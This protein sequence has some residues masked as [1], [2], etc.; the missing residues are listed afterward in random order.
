MPAADP[1]KTLQMARDALSLERERAKDQPACLIVIRG[2]PQGRRYTL[3]KPSTVIGRDA[4]ADIVINDGNVSRRHAEVCLEGD[5]VTLKDCGSTN[6][7]L[8]NTTKV[9][10]AVTLR[11]EDMITVG[12]TILKYLP[13]GELE[14]F[15]IGMLESAAHTDSLTT[16]YNKGYVME[17]LEADFK[18]ARALG[19]PFS[20]LLIDLDHFKHVND[21]HG[22]AA[23]DAVLRET[24]R[25][26]KARELPKE[27]VIGRFGGEEFL[28]LLPRTGRDDALRLAEDL[29]VAVASHT[30]THDGTA[31][32]V[33]CSIGAA[34][35]AADVDSSAA[36]FK[37]ADTGVYRAKSDGRNCVRAVQ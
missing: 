11:K 14:I 12:H 29:R 9:V 37:L 3:T 28:V 4:T 15:Y 6:G 22:H 35:I 26:L 31:I 18:R 21:T 19:T 1:S 7:T 20:L 2:D 27:A 25:V 24:A 36:L 17:A 16:V 5:A 33:T 34:A 23:G 30:F 32:P 10:E 13:K 8:V